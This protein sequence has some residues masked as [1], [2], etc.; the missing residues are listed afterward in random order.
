[1]RRLGKN[2]TLKLLYRELASPHRNNNPSLCRNKRFVNAGATCSPFPS[3]GNGIHPPLIRDIYRMKQP[4]AG[5]ARV[6]RSTK[7][8]ACMQ[9]ACVHSARPHVAKQKRD[10][11]KVRDESNEMN[12]TTPSRNFVRSSSGGTQASSDRNSAQ[13]CHSGRP[14]GK[15]EEEAGGTL[16]ST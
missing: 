11:S 2:A 9:T 16:V 12:N 6:L 13:Y 4:S 1:M 14:T 8:E 7:N 5:L 10:R 3:G 15:R